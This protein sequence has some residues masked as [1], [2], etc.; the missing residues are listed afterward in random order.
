M[1]DELIIYLGWIVSCWEDGNVA[2]CS[3]FPI[4]Y[5]SLPFHFHRSSSKMAFHSLYRI[6]CEILLLY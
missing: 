5:S 6:F 1:T 3:M 2:F 4:A